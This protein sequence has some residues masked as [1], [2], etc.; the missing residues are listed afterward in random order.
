MNVAWTSIGG[1]F[2]GH[3]IDVQWTAGTILSGPIYTDILGHKCNSNH[4][5]WKCGI[6]QDRH[7]SVRV[8]YLLDIPSY[9]QWTA[10]TILSGPIYWQHTQTQVHNIN[11]SNWKCGMTL[12]RQCSV[13]VGCLLNINS[14]NVQWTA[15]TILSGPVDWWHTRTQVR[16]QLEV[17]NDTGQTLFSKGGMFIGHSIDVQWTVGTILSGPALTTYSDTS[18]QYQSFQL[19]V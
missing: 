8:G 9:V 17:W 11:H 18:A 6:T 5:N 4:S 7:C 10:G 13:R 12:D 2:I 14:I 3:P 16:Y 19:E 15:G 1:I